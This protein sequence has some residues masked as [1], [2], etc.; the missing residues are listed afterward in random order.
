MNYHLNQNGRDAG[1]FPLEE[2]RRRREAGGLSGNE[3]VWTEGM[4][5]W[6]SL[7]SVLQ[8]VSPS[9]APKF[10]APPPLPP[11]H[12]RRISPL[13]IALLAIAG[14]CF[15][16][17]AVSIG[18]VAFR[19]ARLMPVVSGGATS[20]QTGRRDA[21]EAASRPIVWDAH[22]RTAADATK[23]A[24][25]FRIRQYVE[26][27]K[28]RGER[29]PEYDGAALELLTNWLASNY[30][31]T[32]GTNVSLSE[33][34]DRLA[35]DPAC[36]DPLLLA[37]AGMNSAELHEGNRRLE[38]A[39]KGFENS[40]HLG[41][42]KF[43]ATVML[44]SKLIEDA[45]DR[46]P[47]LDAQAM[48]YLKAA[49][50]DGSIQP[51]DQAQLAEIL[52]ND[53]GAQFFE[54][55]SA[56]VCSLVQ[57]R[58]DAYQW[59]ALVLQG[60]SEINA[61]WAAR[62][63]GYANTVS[64]SGWQGFNDHLAKAR[65]CLTQAWQLHP[66]LPLAPTLMMKVSLGDSDITE[67]RQWF[68]RA[69]TAQLDY[70]QAWNE[71]RW[72]LRPRWYGDSGSMLA[73]GR[74]ALNSK[75]FDT[76]VPRMFFDSL[77]DV[78][79]E[80]NLPA[81]QRLFGRADIWPDIQELYAGYIA[82]PS[83]TPYARDGW[84][85]TYSVVAYLAGHYDTARTQLEAL[86]W[87]PHDWSLNGWNRD[88]SVMAQEVA[89]RTSP[90]SAQ[91]NDAE[92]WRDGGNVKE[93]L[94]VYKGLAAMTNLDA[95]TRSFVQDRLTTLGVEQR[96]QDHQWVDFLPADTN[97]TGWHV[98]F[99]D[100]KLLPGG[101]LEVQSGQYGHLIYSRARMGTEFE[102]RGQFEVVTSTTTA[103]QAGLVMGVPQYENYNWYAF[104]MKRN[105]D[106]HDVVSF[107]QH[108]TKRQ[109]LA[110]APLD[111]RTNTFDV[112]F[113]HGRIS[114]TVDGREIFQ[115]V[116]P[117]RNAYVTTNEFYLG[118]GAFND[119]NSTVIRYRGIQARRL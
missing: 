17:V 55:N 72:G 111:S 89:A 80:M 106:E 5:Q 49:L 30:G 119:S 76:D 52:V 62:G 112:R 78:E 98:A 45:A 88:L 84:R 20:D 64:E 59:L 35:N 33:L 65:K 118:L 71:M 12:R 85:S 82:E 91:V 42:P 48:Q 79:S 16:I 34:S 43:Y 117:P 2:L 87:Q 66:E 97:F 69:T 36:Q 37:V 114:A 105:N 11:G 74:A 26:G 81:G 75:R 95:Q 100:F 3:Q 60:D 90:Q 21:M 109:I 13:V 10:I 1:I 57:E 50:T 63:G 70:A 39:V 101:A 93:A 104:R 94:L 77:S 9:A 51:G 58:G 18:V 103:F 32:M 110:T 83:L 47:V 23:A 99:G 68:D 40:R 92:Q 116:A 56:A 24:L 31:G 86:H 29:N 27:Y 22:T 7:D 61:A 6:Q 15:L 25:D 41:Y 4:A 113:E 46:L 53:W 19:V 38:R 96:L 102:V 73:F 54:R 14:L 28:L 108:W 67:M 8:S 107:S 115:A 44:S